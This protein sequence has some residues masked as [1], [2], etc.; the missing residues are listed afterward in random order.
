[1]D[2]LDFLKKMLPEDGYYCAAAFDDGFRQKFFDNIDDLSDY[3]QI[4][5]KNG[6][7]VYFAVSSFSKQSRRQDY[8]SYTKLFAYDIDVG[9]K[10][11]SYATRKE[12]MAALVEFLGKTSLPDPTIVYS[13]AGLH[14]YWTL[15][16]A[17]PP[18][19]WAPVAASLKALATTHG[20]IID[21]T[22]T[23]DGA[24]I[25]RPVGCVHTKTGNIV[26]VRLDSPPVHL[27]ELQSK[28]APA[29]PAHLKPKGFLAN[30][31]S[32]AQVYPPC[33]AEVVQA[34]C[35][36]IAWG[37]KNQADVTEPF[38]YTLIG[39]AAYTE[40]PEDTAAAWSDKHPDYSKR[41]TLGKLAQWKQNASGPSTCA[42]FENARPGGCKGCPLAG[43][44]TT[45]ASIGKSFA[46]A[47]V[48]ATAPDPVDK[49]LPVPRPFKRTSSGIKLTLEDTDVDVCPF[50]IYPVSYGRD[51]TL[52][53]ETVR[54]HW[55]RPHEGWSLLTFR[56][57]LLVEGNRD[58]STV[59]A[60]QGIVLNNKKQT[61]LFQMMLRSYQAEL[62]KR[63]AL[64]NLYASMGWKEDN[65][66]FV[67]GDTAVKVDLN[68][69][70]IEENTVL[71]Q[72][73]GRT[74]LDMYGTAGSLADWSEATKILEAAN[75]PW[76]QFALGMGFAAPLFNFTGLKGLT[77]SLYGP[78]G[79]GKTLIQYWI[80]SIYGDPDKL[81]FA[82][83]FTQNSLFSR[84][85]MY[86]NL[87]MTIDE[88]TMLNDKEIS[89]FLYWVSQGRDKARLSRSSEERAAK[90]WATPVIVSTN[91][92]L[93]S[94][95][96]SSGIDTDATAARLL[97]VT[98]PQHK[99]FRGGSAAGQQIYTHLMSNYGLAGR[100]FIKELIRIGDAG[101]R[102]MIDEAR[103][104]FAAKYGAKFSGEERFWEQ[105]V[106]LAD[107]GSSIAKRLGLIEYDYTAGTKWVLEQLNIT[108]TSARDNKLDAFDTLSEYLN[109]TAYAAVTS[110][111][112]GSLA[113]MID[114][115]SLPKGEVR[116]RFN[117]SRPNIGAAF[118]KGTLLI[119]RSHF[120]K[121]LSLKGVDYR[122]FV[123]EIEAQGA[124]RT[125]NG[126]Q[127]LG[128]GTGTK[129]P[130]VWVL[131]FDLAHPRLV[132]ILNEKDEA[133]EKAALLGLS[134]ISSPTP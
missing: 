71:A 122:S 133:L 116:A 112:T 56:Q 66:Q 131:G 126:R 86:N 12:A 27:S 118:D 33:R 105:A 60:D 76:H 25:L 22:V 51:E 53:Y 99:L 96:T 44:I 65:K 92:S 121:W 97:E 103:N 78:T 30:S 11:N 19:L 20:L 50:D 104:S 114:H 1:M 58:F 123:R 43:K 88:A 84:L 85:A 35:Q 9:K 7:D 73:T 34:K 4:V 82:A 89:D 32:T 130:P 132:G 39:V 13:G 98:I 102:K 37:V 109:E 117:I 23:T 47:P 129:V 40:D 28:L 2:T 8:I 29:P 26:K 81:H 91:I 83:K 69:N 64:S 75:M 49:I 62:R 17:V 70:V 41:D 108:R 68:G 42:R 113:P 38:W 16:E 15:T 55:D 128:K 111:H 134:V 57:A 77:I 6:D 80:Q 52:G 46:E 127:G 61:D 125:P 54:F 87:P 72:G 36:Q 24:R 119:D 100:E 21:P 59:L 90:T 110:M 18:V 94:K 120:R 31:L 101:L 124:D 67:L 107:L 3:V 14:V 48:S 95:L 106:I 115:T 79:G 10:D 93:A 45:P 63:Q 74:S 5:S